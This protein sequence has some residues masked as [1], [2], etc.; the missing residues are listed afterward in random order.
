MWQ[1]RSCYDQSNVVDVT[2]QC[3][4]NVSSS[5][6]QSSGG[7]QTPAPENSCYYGNRTPLR[8]NQ[9]IYDP[10][11]S[12]LNSEVF[13]GVNSD[14][15]MTHLDDSGYG[16]PFAGF[17]QQR[18]APCVQS[19]PVSDKFSSCD[20]NSS[21][22]TQ[23]DSFN[24][25]YT[26][27]PRSSVTIATPDVSSEDMKIAMREKDVLQRIFSLN[28]ADVDGTESVQKYY[29]SQ[30]AAIDHERHSVL[31]QMA[32][33]KRSSESVQR[34]YNRK[35]SSLLE[36]VEEKLAS[37]ENRKQSGGKSRK[38]NHAE[39]KSRLLPKHAVTLMETWYQ[40]NL[41]NPYPSRETTLHMA[42]DGGIS[43]E[44]IRKWFANKRN[45]SR[46]DKLT[47]SVGASED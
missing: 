19:V 23:C 28:A 38:K 47:C 10:H 45:R 29:Q 40:E 43:V 27:Q 14:C 24:R 41:E 32:Y 16:S 12:G 37:L 35:L 1:Q 25:I 9:C 22:Y 21:L 7:C 2:I 3:Q 13:S 39:K 33:D 31:R 17:G 6:F 20:Y 11:G 36:S 8:G 5:T 44:Q 46:N 26:Q 34:Y 30:T 18:F 42:S 15:D 4:L